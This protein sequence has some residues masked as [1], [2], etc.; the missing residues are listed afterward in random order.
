[1]NSGALFHLFDHS[2][3]SQRGTGM[4]NQAEQ[5]FYDLLNIQFDNWKGIV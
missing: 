1:M 5:N 3:G 4:F 2:F